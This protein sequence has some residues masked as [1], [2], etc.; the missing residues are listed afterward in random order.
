MVKPNTPDASLVGTSAWYRRLDGVSA[1]MV[2]A[3]SSPTKSGLPAA[4]R[5]YM[6]AT[7]GVPPARRSV[8][9]RSPSWTGSTVYS[10]GRVRLG[11]GSLPSEDWISARA[12]CGS[13]L[14]ATISTALSGW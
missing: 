4:G 2:A 3:R 7:S 9:E 8:T 12:V 10:G 13:N 14:P 5:W 11:L 1:R 6:A